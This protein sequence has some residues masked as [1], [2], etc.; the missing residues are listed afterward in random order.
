MD[1]NLTRHYGIAG[2]SGTFIAEG[3]VLTAAHCFSEATITTWVR[4]YNG[5][6]KQAFLVKIDPEY[7]LA[8]LA[9]PGPFKHGIAK[10]TLQPPKLGSQI[11]NVGSPIGFEF[12]LSE[13]VVALTSFRERHFKSTYLV[14]TAMINPGSSGGGAFNDRGELVGVNTMTAGSP[15]GWAGISMA[16]SVEDI[17]RFLK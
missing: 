17:R 13:G 8:L 9:V 14:T 15:F 4:P 5:K 6:S 10:L 16:V 3:A 11:V 1:D 7:D 12:L 2:C